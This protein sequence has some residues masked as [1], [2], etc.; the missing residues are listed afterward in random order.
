VGPIMLE[1]RVYYADIVRSLH[2]LRDARISNPEIYN[3]DDYSAS[4]QLGVQLKAA[5]SYGA[6]YQSVRH[7]G[8]ECAAV[9]RPPALSPVRQG[10]H[11]G[12]MWNGHRIERVISLRTVI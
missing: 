3:L 7:D 6:L 1:M 11:Y 5:R 12:Y 4:R 8:G 2:D 9:F 10:E